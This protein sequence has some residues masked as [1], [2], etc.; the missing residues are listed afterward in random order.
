MTGFVKLSEFHQ[1]NNVLAANITLV[2][3]N[4]QKGRDSRFPEDLG[5]LLEQYR[6]D[7]VFLQEARIDLLQGKEMGGYF[8]NSWKYPW[9]GGATIGVVTLS[10][11]EPIRVQHVPSKYLEFFVTTPK[12]SL[13]T[14]YLLP[15]GKRLLAVNAH[16]L[17]FERWGTMKFRSQ[18][19]ELQSIIANHSGPV[20]V[21][22]DFNTWNRKRLGLVQKLGENLGLKEVVDFPPGRTTGDLQ[23]SL[24]NWIFG[25]NKDLPLDRVYHRGFWAHFPRLLS[26]ESSDHRPILVNLT[27]VNR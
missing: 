7:I 8:A 22:G 17:T 11:L 16:L 25:I 20:I 18:L 23:S 3:W 10:K 24:F 4:V 2:S 6:P 19:D 27:Y 5:L 12:A 21:A 26:Y 14:E 1:S 15:K 9:P 13:I